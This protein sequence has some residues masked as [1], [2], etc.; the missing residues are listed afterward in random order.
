MGIIQKRADELKRGDVVLASNIYVIIGKR[1]PAGDHVAY[2]AYNA[3]DDSDDTFV[4]YPYIAVSVESPDLTPAQQH[5]EEL[6]EAL[7]NLA[8][9]KTTIA[10][11]AA[12][13]VLLD[14]IKPPEPPTLVEALEAIISL[15]PLLIKTEPDDSRLKPVQAL[16]DRARRAGILKS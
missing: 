10:Q 16:L 1:E 8:V 7:E 9:G 14:K 11:M 12:A 3:D 13:R 2:K 5:A 4:C 15:Q 6:V